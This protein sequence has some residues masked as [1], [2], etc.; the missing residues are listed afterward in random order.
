MAYAF[1]EP[2][3]STAIQVLI[4]SLMTFVRLMPKSTEDH[5]TIKGLNAR[6]RCHLGQLSRL[7]GSAL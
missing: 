4:Q 2:L 5:S 3:E 7:F 1:I 6:D